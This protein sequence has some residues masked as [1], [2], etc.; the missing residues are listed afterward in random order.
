MNRSKAPS[1]LK[2]GQ[3]TG[4]RESLAG[5][6]QA[7]LVFVGVELVHVG[8]YRPHCIRT[9]FPRPGRACVLAYGTRKLVRVSTFPGVRSTSMWNAHYLTEGLVF[10][11]VD[12]VCARSIRDRFAAGG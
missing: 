10:G 5:Y 11:G 7:F 1:L 3:P 4:V 12:V 6:A 2:P 8:V 9:R